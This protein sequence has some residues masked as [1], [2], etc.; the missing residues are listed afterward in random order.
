MTKLYRAIDKLDQK[1]S[2]FL[3][4]KDGVVINCWKGDE[5]F[6]IFYAKEREMEPASST[7]ECFERRAINPIL[8]AEW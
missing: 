6:E 5:E 4:M 8:I 3:I 2:A 7:F 1:D